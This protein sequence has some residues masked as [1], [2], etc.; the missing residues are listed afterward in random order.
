MR[1]RASQDARR[2]KKSG[3]LSVKKKKWAQGVKLVGG[4]TGGKDHTREKTEACK[5]K[6]IDC[7]LRGRRGGQQRQKKK[8]R[9]PA[10]NCKGGRLMLTKD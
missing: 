9:E 1:E 5:Q 2:K 7:A 8:K 4:T 3:E 6:R 10:R